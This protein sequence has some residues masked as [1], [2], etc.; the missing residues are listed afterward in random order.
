VTKRR[1]DLVVPATR[2][3]FQAPET[4]AVDEETLFDFE[5]LT[6]ELGWMLMGVGVLGVIL[7]GLPG[8]P[9]FIVGGAGLVP[10]GQKRISRW[11]GDDPKPITKQSL[12]IIGRF[13]NDLK[14]RYP[15]R[16]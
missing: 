8:A 7:P 11:I 14:A 9:F 3:P 16:T 2:A 12:N 10:G 13:V 6:P 15:R 5:T 1:T 4:R